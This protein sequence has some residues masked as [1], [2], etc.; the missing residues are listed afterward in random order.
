MSPSS[1][2]DDMFR[3]FVV[4][5]VETGLLTKG[6]VLA[7]APDQSSADL[8]ATKPHGRMFAIQFKK[9]Q[10]GH[11]SEVIGAVQETL[12]P[13]SDRKKI[14]MYLVG[15]DS[16]NE[17]IAA[18]GHLTEEL[19]GIVPGLHFVSPSALRPKPRPKMR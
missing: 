13:G 8:V 7:R 10:K 11:E 2:M 15:F 16:Q 18:S 14:P 1:K 6:Y 9:L 5:A 19:K 3:D 17:K 4:S 12:V